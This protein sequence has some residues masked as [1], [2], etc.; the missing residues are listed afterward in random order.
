MRDNLAHPYF[1]TNRAIV[2]ATSVR[3][4]RYSGT[5]EVAGVGL[6]DRGPRRF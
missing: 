4:R 3:G 6:I 2:Q 1:D 5:A